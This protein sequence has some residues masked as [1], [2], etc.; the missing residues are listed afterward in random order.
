MVSSPPKRQC[1]I[2]RVIKNRTIP[3]REVNISDPVNG[4]SYTKSEVVAVL[5]QYNSTPRS[6]IQLQLI[7]RLVNSGQVKGGH[8]TIY[9]DL[10]IVNSGGFI[11]HLDFVSR[12]QPRIL[13]TSDMKQNIIEQ[14]GGALGKDEIK[15]LTIDQVK[16]TIQARY[17]VSLVPNLNPSKSSVTNYI[18]LLDHQTSI[19][20]D[21]DKA[22]SKKMTRFTADN[23]I[24]A[25]TIYTVTVT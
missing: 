11:N 10:K 12:G 25:S 19:S 7:S 4:D 21:S 6:A 22:I 18:A 2:H 1:R 15:D 16:K 3:A 14:E 20:I 5:E 17:D 13:S 24:I 9:R 8:S 23:S